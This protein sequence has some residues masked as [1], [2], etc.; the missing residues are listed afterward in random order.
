MLSSEQGDRIRQFVRATFPYLVF[1]TIFLLGML[2]I[3]FWAFTDEAAPP[4]VYERAHAHNDYE[5]TRPLLDALDLGFC[6]VEA[7]IYLING[8][9]LVAHDQDKVSPERTLD[10]LYLKPLWD[11]FQANGG[12][13][14]AQEAPFTLLVDIKNNGA[15]TYRVLDKQLAEYAPMLSTFTNDT[16]TPGAVTVII[17]GDRANDVILSSSPRRAGIDGRLSDL[18]NPVNPHVM[19]L[20]SDNWFSHFKWLGTGAMSPEDE[21]KLTEVIATAHQQGV[22]IRFWAIP[23]NDA[24]WGRLY[25]AGVDLLNADNLAALQKLLAEKATGAR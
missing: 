22:R 14:Y 5:H 20:I 12:H 3:M 18:K 11:R 19:P 15:E 8:E 1:S 25:D 2:V 6:S 10:S 7:D 23:Q 16:T 4:A 9:L 21:S 13:V 17:S 24:V